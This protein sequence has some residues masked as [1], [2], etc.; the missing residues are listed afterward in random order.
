MLAT[1]SWA[2]TDKSKDSSDIPDDKVIFAVDGTSYIQ[3]TAGVCAFTNAIFRT[4]IK[5]FQLFLKV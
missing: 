2:H 5:G 1:L 3:P 4:T